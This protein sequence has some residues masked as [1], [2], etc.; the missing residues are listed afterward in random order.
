MSNTSRGFTLIEIL[1]AILIGSLVLTSIYGV[2][3]SVSNARNRLET[4]GNLYHQARIFFDRIGG[5]LSS[6]RS[7]SLG[8]QAIFSSGKDPSGETFLEFNTGLGSPGLQKYGGVARVRYEIRQSD[9]SIDLLRSEQ[10]LLA[11]LAA[12]E[13]L[14]FIAGLKTFRLRYFS[15][16]SW[17][18]DWSDNNPPQ[19]VEITLE[20]EID[21]R[22]IT[23]RSSFVLPGVQE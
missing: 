5:E 2:F 19:S 18:D 10:S 23:F 17:R 15:Q 16:G 20:L 21:Q 8:K 4:E 14:L 22:L 11:D 12:S 13:P 7:S 3:S 9:E 1:L 6:M